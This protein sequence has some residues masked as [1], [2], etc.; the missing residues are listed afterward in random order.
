MYPNSKLEAQPN[1]VTDL[2]AQGRTG[3]RGASQSAHVGEAS[4]GSQ[5]N[6]TE[7]RSYPLNGDFAKAHLKQQSKQ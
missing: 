6:H 4:A 5:R 7:G 1:G 3:G 2:A